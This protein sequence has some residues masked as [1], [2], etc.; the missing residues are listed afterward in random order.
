MGTE[1]ERGVV[2]LPSKFQRT[3]LKSS[4]GSFN[5]F[6]PSPFLLPPSL[7]HPSPRSSSSPPSGSHAKMSPS[8]ARTRSR[9][10]L[11][12]YQ[13]VFDAVFQNPQLPVE[14][15]VLSDQ[16]YKRSF[17]FRCFLLH[18]VYSMMHLVVSSVS[19]GLVNY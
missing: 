16:L 3:P 12:P 15:L 11:L 17:L 13:P 18:S 10:P 8:G 4:G 5:C 7:T 6:P 14:A 1:E 2:W 9:R 19:A